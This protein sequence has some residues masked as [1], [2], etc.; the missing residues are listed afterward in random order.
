VGIN[1]GRTCWE[2]ERS[3]YK[4]QGAKKYHPPAA[5][6]S[7][8]LRQMANQKKNKP[9]I[10]PPVP[11]E[12]IAIV[13]GEEDFSPLKSKENLLSCI[14]GKGLAAYTSCIE[15][16]EKTG[17]RK[18]RVCIVIGNWGILHPGRLSYLLLTSSPQQ[19][20]HRC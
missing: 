4:A 10:I 1:M 2:R 20:H 14:L 19:N 6:H 5:V 12:A 16:S 18:E 17:E 15:I 8:G 13:R 7:K 11:R 3:F 9:S